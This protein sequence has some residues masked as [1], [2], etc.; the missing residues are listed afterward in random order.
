MAH[1][2]ELTPLELEIYGHYT[3]RKP[4][5]IEGSPD[6]QTVWLQVG[7]QSFQVGSAHD[8]AE[9]ADWL[10]AMLAKALAAIHSEGYSKAAKRYRDGARVVFDIADETITPR[11]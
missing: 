6:A 4:C 9:S 3:K 10:R 5:V 7:V 1:D 2:V 8:T 11:R